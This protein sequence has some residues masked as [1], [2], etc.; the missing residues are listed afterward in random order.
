MDRIRFY[1]LMLL[2]TIFLFPYFSGQG[3]VSAEEVRE[4]NV[5]FRLAFGAMVGPENDRRLVAITRDTVLKSGDQLKMMVE[6][7]KMCFLYLFY[8][9]GT[10]EFDM[11]FPYDFR[12]FDTDYEISKR[13]YIPRRGMWFELDKQI[14]LEK[15][16]LLASSK[17]LP[18]IEAL[19]TAYSEADS[20]KKSGL[21]EQIFSKIKEL[22][23]KNQKLS[24]AAERP[25]EIGG[26][27][28]GVRKDRKALYPD[29]DPIAA[30]VSA[31]DFYSRTFTIEHQ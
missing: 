8:H 22:K 12:Q 26:N 5:N 30:E 23:R 19:Y 20:G 1:A 21:S 28:R 14:G 11:L 15:F 24:T 7:K 13:Y 27:T 16:Y 25:V 9:T 2:L 3:N 29:I 17:R 31:A 10:G 4:K 6:L 18:E